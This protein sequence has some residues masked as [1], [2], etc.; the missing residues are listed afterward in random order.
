MEMKCIIIDHDSEAL[1]LLDECIRRIPFL[2]LMKR[3]TS[4]FEAYT[5]L[6]HEAIDLIFIETEFP[7]VSGIEYISS[8]DNK[9]M[10]VFVTASSAYAVD[11]FELNAVDYVMKPIAF[12]RFLKAANKAFMLFNALRKMRHDDWVDYKDSG[13]SYILVKSDYKSVKVKLEQIGYI[14]GLKDYVKIYLQDEEKPVLTLN[15]LKKL[16]NSLPSYFIRIHK[17]FIVNTHQ[18]KSV[19]RNRV[20]VCDKWL[21]V[22]DSYKKEFMDAVNMFS[23]P[24]AALNSAHEENK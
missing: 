11:A 9:P 16:S 13:P 8:L 6:R 10:V 2:K 14:E 7:D 15:S 21:P 18:I 23:P 12:S 24:E 17:S 19:T 22:G 4:P 3:C 5:I 20:V 1:Q